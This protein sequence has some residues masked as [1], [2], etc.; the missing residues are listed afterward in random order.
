MG[1]IVFNILDYI[2]LIFGMIVPAFFYLI[3]LGHLIYSIGEYHEQNNK[4]PHILMLLMMKLLLIGFVLYTIYTHYFVA[5]NFS[6]V[7]FVWGL[8][9]TFDTKYINNVLA[10]I[11]NYETKNG[12]FRQYLLSKL[13]SCI[14]IKG[15]KSWYLWVKICFA[16]LLLFTILWYYTIGIKAIISDICLPIYVYYDIRLFN[17]FQKF[18]VRH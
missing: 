3:T 15:N 5:E 10:Y 9:I 11:D 6:F 17:Y 4:I 16:L 2:F 8:L 12:D 7:M 13:S 18:I 1:N 14:T